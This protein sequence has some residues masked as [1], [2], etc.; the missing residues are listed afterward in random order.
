MAIKAEFDIPVGCIEFTTHG[1][2][3]RIL[4]RAVPGSAVELGEDAATN[5]A[6]LINLGGT[7]IPLTCII[8]E[9]QA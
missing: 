4:I 6:R 7:G 5:L 1:N 3:D 9:K 8:K 2:G